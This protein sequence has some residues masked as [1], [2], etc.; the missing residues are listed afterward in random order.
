M[1]VRQEVDAGRTV[2]AGE[3]QPVTVPVTVE[4]VRVMSKFPS[5]A[6]AAPVPAQQLPS[7]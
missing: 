1:P 2:S 5:T 7:G 3:I 4:L 6:A